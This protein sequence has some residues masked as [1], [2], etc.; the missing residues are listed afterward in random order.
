MALSRRHTY[1][2]YP[3]NN[4]IST[5]SATLGSGHHSFSVNNCYAILCKSH[6]LVLEKQDT[7]GI[8]NLVYASFSRE[9]K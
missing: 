2:L 1:L 5:R 3:Q 6:L 9:L 8:S 4:P 7:G